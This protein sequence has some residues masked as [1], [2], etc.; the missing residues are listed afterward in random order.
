MK[1]KGFLISKTT[2]VK[3]R[4]NLKTDLFC[5]VSVF[6]V[7]SFRIEGQRSKNMRGANNKLE[8]RN[9]KVKVL[10]YRER[11]SGECRVESVCVSA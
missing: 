1:R 11:E 6:Y 4:F 5:F 3:R 2:I 9:L 7:E 10:E 8:R